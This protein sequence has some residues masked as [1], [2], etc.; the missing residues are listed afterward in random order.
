MTD[1]AWTL[2]TL[3]ISALTDYFK[4]PRS[5]TKD[6]YAQLKASLDKFGMIDK[7]I[8]NADSAHTVIGGHQRLHV[9]RAEGVKQIECWL[10]SRELDARE[11][12]E[13]NIRLN[14][15][16]GAWDFD[17]LAN[18]WDVPDLLEWGFS[19]KELQLGGFDMDEAKGDD[20]GA[21]VDKAE[22]LRVKWGVETGQLWKLGEHL[23]YCGD[24]TDREIIKELF[25]IGFADMC[26][27]DPPYGTMATGRGGKSISGDQTYNAVLGCFDLLPI[28]LKDGAPMYVMGGTFN[29][30]MVYKLFDVTFRQ[31]PTLIVWD[32]EQF[33][34]RHHDYHNQWEAIFYSWKPREGSANDRW[35]G[36]RK[37]ADVWRF[38]RDANN[39]R[40]HIT[41]KPVELVEKAI[42]NSSPNDGVIWEPF[43]GSG[44]TLIAC[45]RLSRKCRAVEISPAYVAVAIQR[46]VDMTGGVP[47]L[48]TGTT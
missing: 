40:V 13:L 42:V 24:S 4:N 45:E 37:Q 5:L 14:K 35:H 16:T 6:Q 3:D 32:K 26:F 22:E 30:P 10:P 20:P 11:V 2:K 27:T 48:M 29:L 39:D 7:P 46:W 25:G 18:Q 1:I 12:E 33:V 38:P 36:D 15:N 43:S 44:S 28:V 9:L 31:V 21:Q 8:I 19:E 34:L 41:Q 23:I 47:E 17:V